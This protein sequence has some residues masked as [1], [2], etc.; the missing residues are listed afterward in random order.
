MASQR[1]F[2]GGR[3]PFGFDVV[4]VDE[5]TSKLVPNATEQATIVQMQTMRDEGATYRV[6]GAAVNLPF[7]TVQRILDR[8]SPAA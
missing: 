5:K 3:K 1:L 7:K 2:S 4:P 6:I 8:Q